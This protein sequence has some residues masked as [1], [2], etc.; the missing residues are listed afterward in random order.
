MA[1]DVKQIGFRLE[2]KTWRGWI[3]IGQW[4]GAEG[5]CA[6]PK[7]AMLKRARIAENQVDGKQF[8]WVYWIPTQIKFPQAEPDCPKRFPLPAGQRRS[9]RPR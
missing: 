6:Q 7:G 8:R 1:D 4:E 9:A 5:Q 3:C 2:Q